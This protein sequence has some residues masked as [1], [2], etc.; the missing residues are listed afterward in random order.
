MTLSAVGGKYKEVKT[1]RTTK[2]AC[3]FIFITR[4]VSSRADYFE[5]FLMRGKGKTK[6]KICNG[7]C[8]FISNSFP[9]NRNNDLCREEYLTEERN[10]G[11]I[12]YMT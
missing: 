8:A 7:V 2:N 1:T 9:R 10:L 11:Y 12:M 5:I 3:G 6:C 4:P